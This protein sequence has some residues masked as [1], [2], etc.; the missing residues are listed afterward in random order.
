M[1][2]GIAGFQHFA[3]RADAKSAFKIVGLGQFWREHAVHQHQPA[4]ARDRMQLQCGAG[5]LQR[6]RI[7]R[8][9][10]RQHLAHQHAQ[11]GVFPVLDPPMRQACALVSLERPLPDIG[12]LARARQPIARDGESVAQRASGFVLCHCNIHA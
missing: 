10:Q 6:R 3:Q 4:H 11:I 5:A 7:R 8:S 2:R 1:E 9:R 12:N